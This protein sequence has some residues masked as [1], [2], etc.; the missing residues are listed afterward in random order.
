MTCHIAVVLTCLVLSACRISVPE[1]LLPCQS[2]QDCPVAWSCE[3]GRCAHTLRESQVQADAGPVRDAAVR[4]AET[5]VVLDAGRSVEP[6]KTADQ[7]AGAA[8]SGKCRDGETKPCYSGPVGSAGR[9]RC[10]AGIV[11]CKRESFGACMGERLP[12]Q[13][14]CAN[15]GV[16]DDCDG[17]VDEDLT[18]GQACAVPEQ[19][20]ECALG[21]LQCQ[22]AAAVPVCVAK[23]PDA[24][25]CNSLDDDCD[26]LTD[27]AFV[28]TNDV[29]NCG[30][31]GVACADGQVCCGGAC[32][33]AWPD[34]YGSTCG[35]RC[36][37]PGTIQCDGS[38]SH[39]DPPDVD[40]EC[41]RCGGRVQ[42]DGSCSQPE[43]PDYGERCKDGIS[44][45]GCS[46]SCEC[47]RQCP[48]GQ[49]VPCAS[50]CPILCIGN[51]CIEL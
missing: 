35:G 38:C 9:G 17:R 8:D 45:V 15:L 39:A 1:G 46:G 21:T 18:R 19:V 30:G 20:G 40:R 42:C 12:G 22:G 44:K 11:T 28:L 13:E 33:S 23:Q 7:D 37:T 49:I 31:C 41:G 32:Q 29:Q 14:S 25:S 6:P 3:R 2:S 51:I 47:E 48:S 4:L 36:D 50:L 16:D 43:P 27:E 34:D 26:G 10:A 5:N 24:E